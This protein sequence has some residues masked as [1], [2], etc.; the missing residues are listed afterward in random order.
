MAGYVKQYDAGW[1]LENNSA[2]CINAT[3]EDILNEKGYRQKGINAK[4][5]ANQVFS[6]R[7]VAKTLSNQVLMCLNQVNGTE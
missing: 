2:E 1:V 7:E 6:W 3:L 4:R 5:L